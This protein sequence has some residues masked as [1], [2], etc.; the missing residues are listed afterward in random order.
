MNAEVLM[1][2]GLGGH[3][4]ISNVDPFTQV[5]AKDKKTSPSELQNGDERNPVLVEVDVEDDASVCFSDEGFLGFLEGEV[6]DALEYTKMVSF[7][8]QLFIN[9]DIKSKIALAKLWEKLPK[10]VA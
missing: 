10:I 4:I 2:D 9:N 7:S 3:V 6:E 8:R 1:G 5:D